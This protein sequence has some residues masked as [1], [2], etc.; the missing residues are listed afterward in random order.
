MS[1]D[2]VCSTCGWRFFKKCH[3]VRHLQRTQGCSPQDLKCNC[4]IQWHSLSKMNSH[5]CHGSKRVRSELK[6]QPQAQ[7]QAIPINESLNSEDVESNER[8]VRKDEANDQDRAGITFDRPIKK[9][10]HNIAVRTPM[11]RRFIPPL[12]EIG[13][14]VPERDIK[15]NIHS[16]ETNIQ[17]MQI[18]LNGLKQLHASMK[19]STGL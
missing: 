19:E 15:I 5:E 2:L 8:S 3:M 13:N 10:R 9:H 4:G 14:L 12:P 16:L 7:P 18:T 6:A 1:S 17:L 11:R